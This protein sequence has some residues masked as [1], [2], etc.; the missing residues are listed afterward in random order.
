MNQEHYINLDRINDILRRQLADA[1]VGM[2]LETHIINDLGADSLDL[3]DIRTAI[4]EEFEIELA[5]EDA[6]EFRTIRDILRLVT[7]TLGCESV[8]E[9]PTADPEGSELTGLFCAMVGCHKYAAGALQIDVKF[10]PL[11]ELHRSEEM[12][13]LMPR[14]IP[15]KAEGPI[16][17]KS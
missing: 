16:Y 17:R 15:L 9:P 2:T 10:T 4:E 6:A 7:K 1:G 12:S 3:V 8:E 5:D 11:C 13:R 14:W